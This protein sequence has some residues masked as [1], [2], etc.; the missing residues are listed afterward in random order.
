MKKIKYLLTGI[1]VLGLLSSCLKEFQELNTDPEKMG[2]ADPLF[3]FTGATLNFNNASR[4]H[5]SSKWDDLV[6]MQY[7]V[8]GGGMS[9]DLYVS[10]T[11]GNRHP[12]FGSTSYNYSDY[13][14]VQSDNAGAYGHRLHYLINNVIPVQDNP[15]RYN[16]LV[17]VSQI[18]INYK[19]WLLLDT[20][21]AAPLTE[22][23]QAVNGNYAPKYD[24]Y[25]ESIDGE[26]MYKLIDKRLKEA[27]EA[28][29]ASDDTQVELGVNDFF[30]KGDLSKWIKAAN[31][32]RVK[33]AQR[34]EKRDKA[35]Y[36]SVI[37]EVLSSK[38][39]VISSHDESFIYWHAYNYNTNVDDMTAITSSYVA[40][41]PF[42]NFLKAYNDPRLAVL[43]RPNGFGLKNNNKNND[44]WW[45]TF[46][47]NYPDNK[48][49]RE[50]G[51]N[52]VTL[53]F[54][55]FVDNRY[56]GMTATTKFSSDDITNLYISTYFPQIAYEDEEGNPQNMEIRMY[57]Q[58]ESRYFVKNGGNTTRNGTRDIEDSKYIKDGNEIHLFTPLLTYPEA[59]FMYAEIALKKG[60]SVAGQDATA[61]YR[62]GIKAS[63]Q[64]VATWAERVYVT[65]QVDNTSDNYAPIDDAKINA[66]LA[67]SEFQSASL[68]KIIS[69]QWVNLFMQPGEM[70]ATWKRTGL[71]AF[72]DGE[73]SGKDGVAL[74]PK[75]AG[76]VAYFESLDEN[77]SLAIPRRNILPRPTSSLNWENFDAA[78]EKLTADAQYGADENATEGRI[79]WDKE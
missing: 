58:F 40:S 64:Q 51:E 19:Q 7:I 66:Y 71:P 73:L 52:T 57:S 44:E 77:N 15:A 45:N 65:S 43:V 4:G 31:T 6:R 34:L 59:C 1:C 32:L 68:E 79:W 22:A 50:V 23:F 18:L 76:G 46:T 5:V 2:E 11:A 67:Q 26:P 3:V 12:S 16:D 27:V 47:E 78:I 8:G 10:G 56:I 41:A 60:G 75:P 14:S 55:P 13:Y 53:D 28:L 72:K 54:T 35:F 48:L 61:W 25:Q 24:L 30:Y 33:M 49:D 69:Q 36:E 37:N 21:G 63:M 62:E 17:A 42:V 20:F 38:D 74:G 29:K 70:W 9:A 39:N